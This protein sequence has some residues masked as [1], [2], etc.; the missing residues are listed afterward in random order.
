MFSSQTFLFP[1][2]IHPLGTV[3]SSAGVIY[4][5][6]SAPQPI[7]GRGAQPWACLWQRVTT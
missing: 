6:P 7:K 4:L 5:G 3:H 2:P 1:R